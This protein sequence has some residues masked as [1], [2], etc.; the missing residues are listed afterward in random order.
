MSLRVEQDCPQCG[1][2]LEMDETDRLLRCHFCS[3]QSFL[4]NTGPLHFILP[5]SQPDPYTIYAPYIRFKGTVFSCLD[6]RIE[7]RLVDISTKGVTLS[8][9]PPSLGLRPQ[10]MKMRFAT[11][12]VPGSFLRKSIHADEILKRAAKNL[13]VRDETILHQAF[14]G[15]ALNVIYLPLSIKDE[16]ILDGV[17]EKTL[18]QIPEGSTPFAEADIGY[19]AWKPFFLS[20]LCPRC[21]WNLEGETN[22]MVLI[23][24]NCNSAWQADGR[25]FLEVT[26]KVTPS[27]NQNVLYIPFWNFQVKAEG[28]RLHSFADFIRLTNQAMVIQPEWEKMELFI[29]TPAFKVRPHDFLRLGTQMTI[30]QRFTQPA[31]DAIPTKN[32][33]PVTLA[34]SDADRSLKVILAHSA[35]SSANIYPH[36]PNIQFEITDYFLHYLPF[37]KTSHELQQNHLG[38][39][40]NQRVLNYGL[41]L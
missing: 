32:L 14:V 9:L 27:K 41:S 37:E 26:I 16:E 13:R 23:C 19:N 12:A 18:A 22:S 24:S 3:V 39:T 40:I 36:L 28:I 15:D 38:V 29:V 17:V 30:S 7:Q 33:Y 4:G 21:G 20:A 2:P 11:P 25:N 1:A 8:F 10:A 6:N 5:R 31:T 34:H 35:V